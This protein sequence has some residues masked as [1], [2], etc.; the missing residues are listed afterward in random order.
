MTAR[1]ISPA[2]RQYVEDELLRAPL[3]FDQ[4]A[5]GALDSMRRGLPA[6][7]NIERNAVGDLMQALNTHRSRLVERYVQALRDKVAEE[8][9]KPAA[10]AAPR[11]A[12]AIALSLVEEDVVALD[13]ELS[14]T[15]QLIKSTAE[16]EL[17]ELATY[18]AALVGD[19]DVA[20]DHNPF[21]PDTHARALWAA[22]QALPMARGHQVSFMRHAGRPLATVLRQSYAAS[23]ARLEQMGVEPATYRTVIMPSGS[24]R[25]S[26]NPVTTFSP[27]LMRMRETMPAPL[28]TIQS[29]S[30]QGQAPGAAQREQWYDVARGVRNQAD[31]QSVELVSRLFEAILDDE[32]LPADV[33]LLVSRLHGPAMRL[34][35]RDPTVLDK[36]EHPLWRFI[37]VLAYEAE[38][39]PDE[40]DPERLRLL[41]L[42]QHI[43]DTLSSTTEQRTS[44]YMQALQKLVDFLRQRLDRRCAAVATQIGALQKFEERFDEGNTV[45]QSLDGVVDAQGME[46]VPAELMPEPEGGPQGVTESEQ[47]LTKLRP[48][49]WVR[50]LLQGRWV[51]AQLLWIGAQREF[52]LFGDG[53]SDATWAVRRGA[54]LMLHAGAL[55]KSLKMRSLVGSAALRVQEQISANARPDG[56]G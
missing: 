13:V 19:L 56:G 25:S 38:M 40:R 5:E 16:Q 37:H 29:M 47:W 52:W 28:D 4:V 32:R 24:R 41:R 10:A 49:H 11:P 26:V 54:L 35:L 22:A 51:Q 2:L 14:H 23:C 20:E 43:I 12:R 17:R 55:A 46:T 33:N 15:T 42:A 21:R 36:D 18:I 48:G 3:L 27:D 44:L 50:L 45:P 30:Y 53:G 9:G 39:V 8:V 1:Q 6:M 31:R 34:T 7:S